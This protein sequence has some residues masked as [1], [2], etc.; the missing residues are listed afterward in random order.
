MAWRQLEK[1]GSSQMWRHTNQGTFRA[2]LRG[3][4]P[5]ERICQSAASWALRHMAPESFGSCLGL[6][7]EQIGHAVT[8]LTSHCF[9]GNMPGSAAA[10]LPL[11]RAAEGSVARAR[12]RLGRHLPGRWP[13]SVPR[14]GTW[15]LRVNPNVLPHGHPPW[16]SLSRPSVPSEEPSCRG[17]QVIITH[18]ESSPPAALGPS[19]FHSD[20]AGAGLNGGWGPCGRKVA[21]TR[22]PVPAEVSRSFLRFHPQETRTCR[23]REA[24]AVQQRPQHQTLQA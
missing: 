20:G 24:R 22:P 3:G 17:S 6:C 14:A 13:V 7:L 4:G 8:A 1:L 11:S 21:P 23:H 5:T 10:V 16:A 2:S 15:L 9:R 19:H 18:T 12:A